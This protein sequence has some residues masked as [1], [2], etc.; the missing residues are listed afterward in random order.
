MQKPLRVSGLLLAGVISE[1]FADLLDHLAGAAYFEAELVLQALIRR[2]FHAAHDI[3]YFE[4]SLQILA[5]IAIHLV[6]EHATVER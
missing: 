5:V 1:S 2:A 4:G 6:F 3:D